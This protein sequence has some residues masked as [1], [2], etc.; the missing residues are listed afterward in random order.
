MIDEPRV[1]VAGADRI[2]GVRMRGSKPATLT[3]RVNGTRLTQTA[4]TA[5]VVRVRW[6]G[7]ASHVRVVAWDAA[8]NVSLPAARS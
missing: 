6:S 1:L 4:A 2:S 7:P 5:G 3:L 8:G